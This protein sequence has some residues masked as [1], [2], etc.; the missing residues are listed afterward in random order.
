MRLAEVVVNVPFDK[1]FHYILPDDMNVPLYSRVAVDFKNRKT[2]AFVTAVIDESELKENLTGVEL[3]T[4]RKLIDKEPI[5]NNMTI[6]IAEWLSRYCL[7]SFGETL[8]AITPSAS[9]PATREE[10][11]YYTGEIARLNVEQQ[12]A[13][14]AMKPSIGTNAAYLLHGVT[15]SGKTEV[16]KKLAADCIADGRSVIILIPEISLTPQTLE[17]FRVSFGDAVA[18]YH[19]RLSQGERLSEWMRAFH[20]EAKIMIGPRSAIFAPMRNLGLIIVDE[21]HE[22]SYKSQNSPRYHARQVAFFRSKRE[23]AALVLGSATPQI[24]TYYH[25]L[26]GSIKLVELKSRYQ[27][28][29]L[30]TVKIVDMKA[31]D[32]NNRAL[33]SELFLSL[34]KTL[35][36]KKQALLFLN[37]RGF[38]PSLICENCGH[39]FECP[40]CDVALTLH[41]ND[42]HLE[43]HHCGRTESVPAKCPNCGGA[44]L[45]EVG[46]GTER[47]E[48]RLAEQ[49]PNAR[50]VRMDAD[51]TRKKDSFEDMW[52]EVKSGRADI[53]VGTQ[54]VAKGH[55]IAGLK[56]VGAIL[57]DITL[58][59]PDFR[60]SERAFILLTQVIG[61]AGRRAETGEAVI[62]TYMPEHYSITSAAAQDYRQFYDVE[63]KKRETFGYPPFARI[64]RIVFRGRDLEV[65]RKF[66]QSLQ[67]ACETF[68][69]NAPDVKILGPV[70]CPME[71]LNNQYRYHIILKSQN[72]SAILKVMNT[73]KDFFK[74]DKNSRNLHIELDLDPTNMI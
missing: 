56:L 72:V 57:P 67:T 11:Y 62:Q 37:R 5:V 49:F 55:D 47:L 66:V 44:A 14:L 12:D 32:D 29:S 39:T 59:L 20:G 21:E 65:L 74:A 26:E 13:Y 61:R 23:N 38:A 31:E 45:K 71:K 63:I 24:E 41:K 27:T 25:A 30:P 17:R 4:V 28:P 70:T 2:E 34:A 73:V 22:A 15:G 40:N 43:C 52:N 48:S 1:R 8:F 7:S 6:E 46:S 19:S 53:L 35:G 54:M 9:K 51:T 3:K 33:S 36:E 64:G 60:S 18:L 68:A 10:K 50:I 42:R 69:R 58:S 16:Y